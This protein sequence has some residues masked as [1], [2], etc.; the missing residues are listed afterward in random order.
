MDGSHCPS[1]GGNREFGSA[2]YSLSVSTPPSKNLSALTAPA[3]PPPRP[4]SAPHHLSFA[5]SV[6]R[7][8]G[9]DTEKRHSDLEKKNSA[10]VGFSQFYSTVYA[11]PRRVREESFLGVSQP[12]VF[13]GFCP[14]RYK[15]HP[16]P[17]PIVSLVASPT[18]HRRAPQGPRENAI[19]LE[20]GPM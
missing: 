16:Y 2:F 17:H 11:K 3:Q 12:G 20:D 14:A 6:F 8:S 4:P 19:P 10:S 13:L 1:R 18:G 5:K 9:E 7:E 15:Q